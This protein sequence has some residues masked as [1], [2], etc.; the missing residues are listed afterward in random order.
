MGME[1]WVSGQNQLLAEIAF[2]EKLQG[3]TLM[4]ELSPRPSTRSSRSTPLPA[5]S[6]DAYELPARPSEPTPR[7]SSSR[8]AQRLCGRSLSGGAHGGDR[9]PP[10]KSPAP[11]RRKPSLRP[12]TNGDRKTWD[13]FTTYT[14]K[15]EQSVIFPTV[16]PKSTERYKWKESD[17]YSAYYSALVDSGMLKEIQDRRLLEGRHARVRPQYD[18]MAE[19]PEEP[20]GPDREQEPRH[21]PQTSMA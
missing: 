2:Y 12:R 13:F 1:G 8:R 16:A 17:A 21:E 3:T 15:F 4:T 6:G 5:S 7:N 11:G 10:E 19:N 9:L 14:E 20:A 18:Q